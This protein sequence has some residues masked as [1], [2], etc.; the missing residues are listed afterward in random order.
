MAELDSIQAVVKFKV[1]DMGTTQ[2]DVSIR[3]G[4]NNGNYWTVLEEGGTKSRVLLDT[5]DLLGIDM[6]LVDRKTGKVFTIK[7]P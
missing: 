2:G 7:K 5:L 1:R 3:L 4:V 6:Q